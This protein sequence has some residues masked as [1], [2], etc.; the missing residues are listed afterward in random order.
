MPRVRMLLIGIGLVALLCLHATAAWASS[1]I[2]TPVR[3]Q[4][5]EEKRSELLEFRNT[6]K[7][8]ARFQAQAEAWYESTDGQTKLVPTRDLL[9]FPSLIEIKPGETRRIRVSS[10][11]RPG[12]VERTYRLLVDEFPSAPVPGVVQ[13][14]TRLSLPIFVQPPNPRP[15]PSISVQLEHG[16]VRVLLA[17]Q[18]NAY[19]KADSVRVV[20]RSK[21]GEVL[22]DK[23][24]RGWYVLAGGQ[25]GYTLEVPDG[26]CA[27]IAQL[28]TTARTEA[29]EASAEASSE[30]GAACAI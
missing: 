1:V 30:P 15:K 23:S 16:K 20:A 10:A 25:R 4:L 12:P 24:L 21:S 17:N 6:G 18:G 26:A 11:V 9:F 2:V 7:E 13:V 27:S 29:G 5:S 19:F 14:L 3:V 22:F 8:T 28:N